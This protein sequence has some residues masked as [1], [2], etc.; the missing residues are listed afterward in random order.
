MNSGLDTDM[1]L[2]SVNTANDSGADKN[3]SNSSI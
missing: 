1:Q 2:I 3:P